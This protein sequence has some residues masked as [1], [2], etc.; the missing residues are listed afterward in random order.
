[1]KLRFQVNISTEYHPFESQE[2]IEEE[3]WLKISGL[4]AWLNI[5]VSHN[6]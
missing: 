5:G 1:M 3:T 4:I 2:L 6:G